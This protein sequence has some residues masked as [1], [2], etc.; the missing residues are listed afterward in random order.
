MTCALKFFCFI[1]TLFIRLSSSAVYPLNDRN[2]SETTG[3]SLLAAG[4]SSRSSSVQSNPSNTARSDTSS[5]IHTSTYSTTS[6]RNFDRSNS[7]DYRRNLLLD[8]PMS[9]ILD[10]EFS[11]EP[12]IKRPGTPA[13]K[14][15]SKCITSCKIL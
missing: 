13:K 14:K 6:R 15:P 5:T 11:K 8:R 4:R 2:D 10:E 1:L 9:V 3:R 12:R 7:D